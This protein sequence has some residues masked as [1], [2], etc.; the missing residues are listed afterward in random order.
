MD[1]TIDAKVVVEKVFAKLDKKHP[2]NNVAVMES[3]A[4]EFI[5]E[6]IYGVL[7]ALHSDAINELADSNG[8]AISD[9]LLGCYIQYCT[10]CS[11]IGVNPIENPSVWLDL[12]QDTADEI[13]NAE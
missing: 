2:E 1:K 7:E 10:A 4:M 8:N 5:R 3:R 11:I 6:A 9:A 12:I 13:M